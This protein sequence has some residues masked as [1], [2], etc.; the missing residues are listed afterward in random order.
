MTDLK[1]RSYDAIVALAALARRLEDEGQ[2]NIAKLARA[3]VTA[4]IRRAAYESRV[5]EGRDALSAEIDRALG[6]LEALQVDAALVGAFRRGAQALHEGRLPLID[7]TPD[8]Y[9][10]RRCGQVQLGAPNKCPTCGA[11]AGTLERFR[12]VYWLDALDP[13]AALERLRQTP[14]EVRARLDGLSETELSRAPAAGEWSARKVLTHLR[15]AQ[16]VLHYR[17]DL[18]LSQD[19][20]VLEAQAVFEWAALQQE[21]APTTRELLDEYQNIRSRLIDRL[22]SIPLSDWWRTGRHTEFGTVTL[23]QQVSYFATHE[24]THLPQLEAL[25]A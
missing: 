16:G 2:I 24:L 9:V 11:E 1:T 5:P 17:T 7:D 21:H 4:L 10:C 18:I 6:D 19:N 25:R 22:E 13:P 23:K 12:P 15:D 3:S 20:P 8:P 14:R